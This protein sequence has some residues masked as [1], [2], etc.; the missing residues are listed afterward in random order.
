MAYLVN[1]ETGVV[2]VP[3]T[4]L[5]PLGE[6]RFV[7]YMNTFRKEI[8]RLEWTLSEGLSYPVII[9]H[10]KPK[11]LS[12]TTYA[13]SD[14]I[15]N[16]Y[17]I[18]FTG[19]TVQ[20]VDLIGS[21]NNIVDVLVYNGVSVVPSNS[22]GSIL[23]GAEDVDSTAPLWDNTIGI[24]NAYQ[25]GDNINVT[26]GKASDVNSVRYNIY[27]STS[28]V[29]VFDSSNLLT[30][31]SGH[32]YSI[33]SNISEDLQDATTYYIGI[34]AIDSIGNET[35]NLNY[36][37]VN[38]VAVVESGAL[39]PEQHNHLL[40]LDTTEIS[41]HN[42]MDSYQNKQ[43]YK[44]DISSLSAD[45]NI[46]SVTGTPVTS[47]DDFKAGEIDMTITNDLIIASKDELI[48]KAEDLQLGNWKIE[49]NQMIMLDV[50]GA[51]IQ[52]FNL[53]DAGGNPTMR[54]VYKRE[55]V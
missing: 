14:E 18:K 21:N 27:I 55:K 10:N 2:E 17:T 8:R 1:W 11:T 7:C 51:E 25:N 45:V 49:N 12:G 41:F 38:Y 34:R 44:S 43:D 31:D 20:R 35:D 52:R 15:I 6:G 19:A 9:D 42:N 39:T 36:A 30:S 28:G 48:A 4:D 26:W 3:E 33:T 13:P 46:V 23:V 53:F 16:N 32:F 29:T 40:G 24:T 22:A 50:A 54:A 5:S 47:I 37:T